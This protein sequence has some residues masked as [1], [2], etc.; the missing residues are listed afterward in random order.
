MACTEQI[1]SSG[2][3]GLKL[4]AY[5]V[6]KDEASQFNGLFTDVVKSILVF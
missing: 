4:L 6:E 3:L 1:Q 5:N 2:T